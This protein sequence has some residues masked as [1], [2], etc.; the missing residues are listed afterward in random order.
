MSTSTFESSLDLVTDFL[1]ERNR[2][3]PDLPT[4]PSRESLD[5]ALKALPTFL[6]ESGWGTQRTIEHVL[7]NVV[8]GLW[9]GHAGNRYFGL[10][11]G[12]VTEGAQLGDMIAGSLDESIQLNFPDSTIG[13]ALED[14][15]CDLVLDLLGIP[16]DTFRGRT[17][18]TGATASN[19][20]GLACA[21]DSLL[22]NHPGL[23]RGWN[24]AE[25]GF[26]PQT[27]HPSGD[28]IPPVRVFCRKAHGSI[29]KAAAVTGIGRRNVVDIPPGTDALKIGMD[30]YVLERELRETKGMGIGCI[31]VVGL[32]EV[33]TGFFAQDV[34]RIADI[35]QKTGAWLHID[36]AFGAFGSL[37]PGNEHLSSEMMRADSLTVDAHKWLHCPYDCALLYTRTSDS[38]SRSF[39]PSPNTAGPAYLA[40]STISKDDNVAED[41]QTLR[42]WH[43][44][45]PSPLNC[46][47]ENS[48]RNRALPL[49]TALVENGRDGYADIVRRNC[50][51]ANC[52]AKWLQDAQAGGEW[53]ELV[54]GTTS[55]GERTVPLNIVLFRGKEGSR[56]PPSDPGS[57]AR[58]VKAINETRRIFV[59]ITSWDRVGA[60]RI[61]VSN[62]RT[63]NGKSGVEASSELAEVKAVLTQVMREM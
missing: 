58:L 51:F 41:V 59:T 28:P 55:P 32:G 40:P 37:L 17:I 49:F 21:R 34:H 63:A 62:W 33:N 48:R 35:C 38:L 54:N 45:L 25:D 1:I 50:D 18:T 23:P 19:I 2:T 14:R 12:G 20:V 31:V 16:P 47:I 15:T 61:A 13:L 6:P 27:L 24:V 10:V 22:S 9:T 57:A 39:G 30:A 42:D 52:I 60:V 44:S 43:Q 8:P 4:R 53:Y 5:T 46:G 7:Q 29:N 11:T 36:A 3:L 56:Y 26:P